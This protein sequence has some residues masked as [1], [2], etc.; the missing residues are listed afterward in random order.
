[1]EPGQIICAHQPDEMR[2]WRA[3]DNRGQRIGRIGEPK[4][5]F[6]IGHNH[7][8]VFCDGLRRGETG[9]EITVRGFQRVAAR[10]NPPDPIQAQPLHGRFS[11]KQMAGMGRIE[12]SAKQ[13]DPQASCRSRKR[14]VCQG[15]V[16]PV[17]LT[18]Y[19]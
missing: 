1:M 8:R 12:A 15:R 7:A 17:P 19:L 18:T 13:A 5:H 2:L 9:G 4:S 16:C 3:G 6:D 10:D 11:D 14:Q